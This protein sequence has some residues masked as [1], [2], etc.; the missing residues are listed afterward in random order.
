MHSLYMRNVTLEDHIQLH[1]ELPTPGLEALRQVVKEQELVVINFCV[2]VGLARL[3]VEEVTF[4]ACNCT[5][6]T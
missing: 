6:N 2:L 4:S 1:G 5:S 3:D